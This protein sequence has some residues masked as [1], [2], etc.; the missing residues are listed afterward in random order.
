M[1]AERMAIDLESIVD[2]DALALE[3]ER[4]PE[5]LVVR[6]GGRRFAVLSTIEDRDVATHDSSDPKATASRPRAERTES[7]A[8]D[9]SGDWYEYVQWTRRFDHGLADI[10]GAIG[11]LPRFEF[12]PERLSRVLDIIASL[13][14][15]DADEMRR[16]VEES[17][18]QS[19][20]GHDEDEQAADAIQP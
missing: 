9:F 6:R 20:T 5:G 2:S 19:S 18:R 10:G 17:L 16:I 12:T 11:P 14:D 4:H 8:A 3:L 15:L 1:V 13:K 7:A